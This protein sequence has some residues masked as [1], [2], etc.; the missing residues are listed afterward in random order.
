MLRLGRCAVQPVRTAL[1][2]LLPGIVRG[3]RRVGGP[4]VGA[5]A[6]RRLG[7]RIAGGAAG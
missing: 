1:S 2:G 6:G 5:V 4:G 3:G 7:G